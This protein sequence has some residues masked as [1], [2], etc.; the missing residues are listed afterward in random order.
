MKSYNSISTY[1]KSNNL[2]RYVE[3]AEYLDTPKCFYNVNGNVLNRIHINE[4]YSDDSPIY[5]S[6]NS[7]IEF[8][9]NIMLHPIRINGEINMRLIQSANTYTNIYPNVVDRFDTYLKFNTNN[10]EIENFRLKS[11]LIDDC[12]KRL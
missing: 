11:N 2:V 12:L 1:D 10:A 4:D 7:I 8:D 6:V 9:D 5:E 3:F